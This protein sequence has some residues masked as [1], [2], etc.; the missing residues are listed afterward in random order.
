VA[1]KETT[2]VVSREG[3]DYVMDVAKAA[4]QDALTIGLSDEKS[5]VNFNAPGFVAA[6]MPLRL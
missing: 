1:N 4:G 2:A 6:V 5:A 3:V